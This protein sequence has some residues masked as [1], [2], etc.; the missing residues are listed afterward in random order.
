MWWRWL[1]LAATLL[2]PLPA[3]AQ[4][5]T[6]IYSGATALPQGWF[7]L[8]IDGGGFVTGIDIQCNQGVGNC[9][10]GNGT[11]TMVN[12][13]DT[14]GAWLWNGSLWTQIVTKQSFPAGDFTYAGFQGVCEIRIAP[15]NTNHLYMYFTINQGNGYVYESLNRGTTWTRTGFSN[16][17]CAAAGGNLAPEQFGPKMAIDPYNET[18]MY[19][20]TETS[21]VFYT[22][23]GGAGAS[24]TFTHL[25]SIPAGGTTPGDWNLLVF[26]P[27]DHT[28]NTIY[29]ASN[30]TG[31]YKCT[32]AATSPS[33]SQLSASGMPTTFTRIMVDA[34]GNLWVVDNTS[35]GGA[36]NVWI[37]NGSTWTEKISSGIQSSIAQ[38]PNTP[39]HLFSTTY[40][41]EVWYSTN[42]GSSF[43]DDAASFTTSGGAVGW[44]SNVKASDTTAA[45]AETAFDPTQ[46]GVMY[47]TSGV[48]VWKITPPTS[49]VAAVYDGSATVGIQN[50]VTMTGLTPVGGPPMLNAWD[51]ALWLPSNPNTPQANYYA[52][53]A[54][55][56]EGYVI[57]YNISTPTTLF[58]EQGFTL[59]G[60]S[61]NGVTWNSLGTSTPANAFGGDLSVFSDTAA[62]WVRGAGSGPVCLTSGSLIGNTGAWS[63][64]TFNN[65]ATVGGGGWSVDYPFYA[66]KIVAADAAGTFCVWNDGG[67]SNM[68]GFYTSTDG[69]A[70]TYQQSLP[71]A[72]IS[73]YTNMQAVPGKTGHILYAP[74]I[75]PFGTLPAT[76]GIWKSTTGCGGTFTELAN[77]RSPF[78]YGFGAAMP[79]SD[80]YP[81]LYCVCWYNGVYG[82]WRAV[83]IDTGS[84]TWT[85]IDAGT[86]TTGFPLG[87]WD[88]IKFVQGDM[89]IA[90]RLYVGFSGSGWAF[91]QF[92]FLLKR[93]LD[94]A[95]ND[96]SPAFMEHV[97]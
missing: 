66:T 63:N 58:V 51:R 2:L 20:G 46:S 38:D 30:G 29:I 18:I 89:N 71:E 84:P 93:D 69:K 75:N 76:T 3:S 73:S 64:C 47:A 41:G 27:T 6:L 55:V 45:I 44:M 17:T 35:T 36:G 70:F 5:G 82:T 86:A 39:T 1:V 15:S 90:G 50:L 52:A 48:G 8:R 9:S 12:R 21:G 59:Y 61:N 56:Q 57:A 24:T 25:A 43:T 62:V 67:G 13:T 65:G 19:V 32:S 74:G 49:A 26:D 83:N 95:S 87:N 54:G 88:W 7:Q 11:V 33:C 78:G 40:K 53:Y 60:S 23:N 94:P 96:N 81:T 28:G 68:G 92:N 97:A 22:L 37:Y 85:R 34:G 80:G 79:G 72:G 10:A 16:V 14:A 4:L 31:I 77:V 42:S 91:G